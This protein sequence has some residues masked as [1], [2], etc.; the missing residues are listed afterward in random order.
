MGLVATVPFVYRFYPMVR[1]VRARL[2]RGAGPV[3][4]VHGSYLQDWLSSEDDD[5]WRVDPATSG[6]SRAFADI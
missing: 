1:E 6:P 2:A 5:N 4:L 3:R